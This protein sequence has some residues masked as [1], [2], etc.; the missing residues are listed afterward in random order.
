[1]RGQWLAMAALGGS[2]QRRNCRV[3]RGVNAAS[4]AAK[5]PGFLVFFL[6]QSKYRTQI[7]GFILGSISVTS[8]I[9]DSSFLCT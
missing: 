1:M 4:E 5:V 8:Q 3:Q 6:E 9:H 2:G 7:F